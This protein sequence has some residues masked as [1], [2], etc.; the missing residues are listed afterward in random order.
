MQKPRS[1][2]RAIIRRLV[3]WSILLVLYVLSIGPMYWYWFDSRYGNGSAFWSSFYEPL[4][5]AGL[6]C[7][8][9]AKVVDD[10][11]MLWV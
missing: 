7:P 10:Y 2:R 11:I 9:L 3:I 6:L 5:Q 4:F 8:P 1:L